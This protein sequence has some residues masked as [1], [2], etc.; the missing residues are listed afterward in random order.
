MLLNPT[1]WRLHKITFKQQ[2][3]TLTLIRPFISSI[4]R[5]KNELSGHVSSPNNPMNAY[6]HQ[7]HLPH[8]SMD[9]SAFVSLL[10]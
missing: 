3:L 6:L 1:S 4:E 2:N 9:S 8:T 7:L 5:G 10:E